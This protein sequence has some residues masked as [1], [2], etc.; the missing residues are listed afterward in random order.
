MASK[1]SRSKPKNK[2]MTS[3]PARVQRFACFGP[4]LLLEGEDAALW[5]DLVRRM[6]AAVKPV[7]I[8]DELYVADVV[9]LQWEMMRYR[10]LRFSLDQA[11]VHDELEVFLTH[12]L[13]YAAY[14]ETFEEVLAVILEELLPESPEK[15]RAEE[16]KELARQYARSQ[17]D[18]VKRV[19][20]RLRAAGL[21]AENALQEVKVKK[22]KELAQAYTRREPEAITLVNELLASTGQSMHDLV[23][24]ALP[25]N[26][27][28]IE[29]IDRLISI[30]ETRRNISLREIERRRTMLGEALRRNL[31]EVEEGEFE[32][33][34]DDARRRT[35]PGAGSPRIAHRTERTH[36]GSSRRSQGIEVN[37]KGTI[38]RV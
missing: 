15:N 8:I 31:Q 33:I 9:A 17:P 24:E 12:E 26:L 16:A 23:L 13:N 1:R 7:D 10:R 34:E 28:Q 30:A 3:A 11:S 6:C 21:D 2:S 37:Q 20:L 32:V 4:R 29:R 27:D 25:Q 36:T 35:K 14:A 19:T 5:D 38:R 18:A 22:A